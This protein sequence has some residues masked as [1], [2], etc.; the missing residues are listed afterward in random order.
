LL[1]DL[2]R[3]HDANGGSLRDF[4]TAAT[5]HRRRQVASTS[6]VQ[7]LTIHRS[8]GL[9]F[10]VVLLPVFDKNRMDGSSGAD[11]LAPRGPSLETEWLLHRPVVA[12]SAMDPVL[13]AAHEQQVQDD[14]YD[15]LCVW[16]VGLTRA[17]H[18]LHVFTI[19]PG[20]SGGTS[21]VSLLH[22]AVGPTDPSPNGRLW[23]A[24]NPDWFE[25]DQK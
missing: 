8:K 11:F 20:K 3:T 21:P 17:K 14:A 9:G 2:A 22:R 16:Y 13:R 25:S 6:N 7:I 5:T 24:G 19:A 4:L 18:A 1:F 12:V 23:E 10:D 15:A